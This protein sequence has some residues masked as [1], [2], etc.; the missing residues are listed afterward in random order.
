MPVVRKSSLLVA[1]LI[2]AVVA[3]LASAV[4]A[5]AAPVAVSSLSWSIELPDGDPLTGEFTEP[6]ATFHTLR[7]RSISR[8]NVSSATAFWSI[9]IAAP[10]GEELHPGEY[11][12]AERAGFQSGRAPGL[13]VSVNSGGCNEVYGRFTI[14]QIA[15]DASGTITMIEM[16]FVRRCSPSEPAVRGD[17][18]YKATP[19]SYRWTLTD[20]FPETPA[21]HTFRGATSTF[22]AQTFFGTN[23][24]RF[25]ASGDRVNDIVEFAAPP[26]QALTIGTYRNV[27]PVGNQDPGRPGFATDRF[28]CRPITGTFTIKELEFG[29]DGEPTAL[30][31]TFTVRCTEF[32]SPENPDVLKGTI[33]FHA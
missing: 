29:A 21:A 20:Q 2:V 19:L 31:A 10:I 1:A 12:D 17:L 14:H 5:H 6:S 22:F 30:S 23:G 9:S 16:S 7:D 33:H 18:K 26:G 28:R 32:P 27:Q 3:P 25:G 15:F 4:P 8:I 13:D 11:R 24:I